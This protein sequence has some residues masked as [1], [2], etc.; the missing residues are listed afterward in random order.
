MWFLSTRRKYK[1]FDILPF[2]G[3]IGQNNFLSQN[4]KKLDPV[5]EI[6][7]FSTRKYFFYVC[8]SKQYFN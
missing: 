4:Q 8:I 6:Y 7:L 2:F 3:H 1:K 5:I